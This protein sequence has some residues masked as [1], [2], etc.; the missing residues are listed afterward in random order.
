MSDIVGLTKAFQSC[1][2]VV[3]G[4]VML[5]RFHYGGAHRISPEAPV[6]VF[7]GDRVDAVLG[8]A[9]NT[10]RNVAS[11][12]AQARLVGL[13]GDD[14]MGGAVECVAARERGLDP[15][16]EREPGRST[17]VK[18]RLVAK[19]Q[20]LIR[21]DEEPVEP[22]APE[23]A[24]RL[25]DRLEQALEGADLLVL[26]DYLK[27][28]LT[29]A[30]I[31]GAVERA[32]AVGVRVVV[33]PKARDLRRY[34]GV[35]LIKPNAREAELMSGV[36]CHDD[37]GAVEAARRIAEGLG[38]AIV[39]ITRGVQGMTIRTNENGEEQVAHLPTEALEVFDVSGA[40]DTV[41]ASLALA[42]AAGAPAISAARLANVAAGLSVGKIGTAVVSASEL[43][44]AARR[45]ELREGAN[46]VVS[47]EAAADTVRMWRD[48][49]FKTVF[50]NGCF[51]LIHPGHVSLLRQAAE[52]GD[53]LV[54]ALNTDASVKRLKGEGR[55]IQNERARAEVMA[56]L[57][58]VDLVV[59]FDEDTPLETIE[60]LRPD[61]VVKG[62]DYKPEEVVGGDI[63]RSYGGEV[64]LAQLQPG[65]STTEAVRRAS[66]GA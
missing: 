55:P 25:L 38:G 53:K 37:A 48:D 12:S 66:E 7:H 52:F 8:G 51:D 13:I 58:G 36:S 54:V 17:I 46:K 64:K 27:G 60:A 65:H 20:Q 59:L 61:I 26:S 56:A 4:D 41:M 11:L 23:T 29:P 28:V 24:A 19:G 10:A 44:E 15:M 35:D 21:V 47:R 34:A 14:A 3:F 39:V 57:A 40:G 43:E 2:L 49:G 16:L 45:S 1:R 9:G 42:L 22:I 32:H 18:T 50:T 5:D 31:A 30:T 33:D 6:P 63:V 62:T